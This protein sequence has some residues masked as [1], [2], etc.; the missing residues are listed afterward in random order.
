M[1]Q[2]RKLMRAMRIMA[3]NIAERMIGTRFAFE[4]V[5]ELDAGPEGTTVV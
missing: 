4:D 5:L 3:P 2:R 1:Y